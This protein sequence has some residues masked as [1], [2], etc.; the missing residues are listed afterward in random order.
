MSHLTRLIPLSATFA[1]LLIASENTPTW[2]DGSD[3]LESYALSTDLAAGTLA[4][5]VITGAAS[6]G[7]ISWVNGSNGGIPTAGQVIV[8]DDGGDKVGQYTDFA[9]Q[10]SGDFEG[11][12]ENPGG[13][14]YLAPGQSAKLSVEVNSVVGDITFQ[15]MFTC[16]PSFNCYDSIENGNGFQSAANF[17]PNGRYG[18]FDEDG[19]KQETNPVGPFMVN[20]TWYRLDYVVTRNDL[21]ALQPGMYSMAV[22]LFDRDSGTQ[23]GTTAFSGTSSDGV[24]VADRNYIKGMRLGNNSDPG[25]LFQFDNLAITKLNPLGA[26]PGTVTAMDNFDG[27]AGG[28]GTN[29]LGTTNGQVSW[30]NGP[31]TAA[32][33]IDATAHVEVSTDT[34]SGSGQSMEFFTGTAGAGGA[35]R[36]ELAPANAIELNPGDTGRVSFNFK[37]DGAQDTNAFKILFSTDADGTAQDNI[38]NFH[39]VALGDNGE[40]GVNN[41]ATNTGTQVFFDAEATESVRWGGGWDADTWYLAEIEVTRPVVGQHDYFMR[42]TDATTGAIM[43]EVWEADVGQGD[44]GRPWITGMSIHGTSNLS[45]TLLIDN[46]LFEEIAS[47]T[48]EDAD[49]DDDDDVDGADFLTWQ[50][51]F[52]LTGQP[53]KSTGDANGDGDVNDLDLAIWET[54]YGTIPPLAGVAAVPEPASLALILL[55]TCGVM[56]SRAW[57]VGSGE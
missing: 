3:N 33:G 29:I 50:R 39:A 36:A 27:I 52:G 21:N 47:A 45:R 16:D 56:G 12:L 10:P 51:G 44:A 38:D 25:E 46:L 20:N 31:L 32:G 48:V 2:A 6:N 17:T 57:G 11:V 53:N 42:V 34:P 14:V 5:G 49:F 15:P 37:A 54:Q 26:G 22:S 55:A 24:R 9:G 18:I 40:F 43:G 8:I 35:F 4:G 7:Q 30:L 41:N 13:A 1:V 23:I 19:I 28:A